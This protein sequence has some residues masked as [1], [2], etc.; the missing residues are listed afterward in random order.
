MR[1]IA[2]LSAF[3]LLLNLSGPVFADVEVDIPSQPVGD[4]L[5]QFAE[6]SGLQVV[7]YAGDAKGVET[8]AV[9]GTFEEPTEALDTLLA[10]TG[11]EY[12]FI[13]DRTVSVSAVVNDE[14]GASDSKNLSPAPVLMA[15]TQTSTQER[16]SESSDGQ[17]ASADEEGATL[18]EIVVTGSRIRGVAPVGSP[19]LVLD[20]DEIQ[21]SGFATTQ[22][23]IQRL[24]QNFRGDA[25]EDIPVNDDS[26]VNTGRGA[27]INLRGLGSS[28]TLVLLNGR[29]ISQ[30]GGFGASYIDVSSIPVS[31]IDRVEVL[32]DGASAIYGSDAIAGVVNFVLRD[33]F[34]GAETGLRY[35]SVT[36]GGLDEI[37]FH[38]LFGT[39]WESGR[40][41]IAYE[42]FDRSNLDSSERPYTADSDLR[43]L[44]GDQFGITTSNPGNVLFPQAALPPNQDGTNLTPADLLLGQTNLQNFNEGRDIFPTQERHSVLWTVNQDVSQSVSLSGELSYFYREYEQRNGGEPAPFLAVPATHPNFV[45]PIPGASSVFLTYNF[46]DDFGPMKNS[47]DTTSIGA[48]A[49]LTI[50][51]TDDWQGDI[52]V[53]YFSNETNEETTNITNSASLTEALGFDDPETPFDPTVDGFFNPFGDGSNTPQNVLDFVGDG[54]STAAIEADLVAAQFVLDGPLATIPGGDLLMAFGLE[55]RQ[56]STSRQS[57]T[58]VGSDMVASQFSAVDLERDIYAAFAELSVPMIGSENGRPG[59]RKLDLSIA[60]RFEDYS[61]FGTTTNPKFGIL[62]SP[63]DGLALRGSWGTSFKAPDIT[64]LAPNAQRFRTLNRTDP[65]SPTGSTLALYLQGSNPD[66]Q[67]EEADAWT[68]GMDIEPAGVPGLGI[69]LTYFNI[70]FEDRIAFLSGFFNAFLDEEFYGPIIDRSPDLD[71]VES[72]LSSDLFFGTPP[73]ADL[74]EA[75]VDG[76]IR[77][78][79]STDVEGIDVHILY[80]LDSRFGQFDFRLNGN[81]LSRFDEAISPVAPVVDVLDTLNNPVDLRMR[82]SVTWSQSGW[83]ATA[84]VNHVGSYEDQLSDP[85]RA[86]DSWTTVDFSLQYRTDGRADM[87]AFDNVGIQLS[88]QNLFDEEPPFV[89]NP[90]G[91]AYDRENATPLGRFVSLELTKEW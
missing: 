14:G 36:D 61:D 9:Q 71:A 29:R 24:P 26:A 44:G 88:V 33:D 8:E 89:N 39:N 20:R 19:M 87:G 2:K 3:V 46:I 74:V 7:M 6:Q 62:W 47:G 82:G 84:F 30:G 54:L 77:N 68:I 60:A 90:A 23:L 40:T 81:Y 55:F 42:Y 57:R 66:I 35:G 58:K 15:Q 75:I 49:G 79:A 1:A 52:S 38:Q 76:R 41:F 51:V 91:V 18:E 27:G 45:S 72:Y 64:Q 31:A 10:S 59:L 53:S 80:G 32:T 11:L 48:A 34:E 16:T 17:F 43:S 83:A 37:Q 69:E 78:L 28:A 86:I 67:P 85:V 50:D 5:N 21:R 12:A 73:P 70:S 65:S 56:E 22:Q 63:V 25:S 4:A 13:N